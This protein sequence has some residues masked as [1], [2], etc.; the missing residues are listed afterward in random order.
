MYK[1]KNIAKEIANMKYVYQLIVK[2]GKIEYKDEY[3]C[4]FQTVR[5][6]SIQKI[7]SKYIELYKQLEGI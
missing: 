2:E 7:P 4:S 3:T 5:N 6:Y 1:G